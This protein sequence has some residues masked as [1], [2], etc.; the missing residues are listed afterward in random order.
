MFLPPGNC[1]G[2]LQACGSRQGFPLAEVVTLEDG[3]DRDFAEPRFLSWLTT[4]FATAALG[5]GAEGSLGNTQGAMRVRTT[6]NPMKGRRA[7]GS[8]PPRMAARMF[9]SGS[10]YDPPRITQSASRSRS[11]FSSVGSYG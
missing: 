2:S 5:L 6:R 4:T 8:A 9:W 1:E 10:P 3:F 11:R 7:P